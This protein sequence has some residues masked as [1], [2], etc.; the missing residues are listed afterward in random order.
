MAGAISPAGEIDIYSV[1]GQT[2]EVVRVRMS[3]GS[4]SP[5]SIENR[6]QVFDPAGGLLGAATSESNAVLDVTLPAAGTYLILASDAGGNRTGTY[7][8][9]VELIP[10]P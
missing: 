8:L 6:V 9:S 5:T 3:D 10:P 2:G 4:P 7:S 1:N